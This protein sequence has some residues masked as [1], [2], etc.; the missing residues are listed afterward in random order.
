MRCQHSGCTHEATGTLWFA[1][2]EEPTFCILAI[3]ICESCTEN[4]LS[5]WQES[6]PHWGNRPCGFI[7]DLVTDKEGLI[8]DFLEGV[9]Q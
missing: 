6:N 3:P 7:P 5:F 9:E 1:Y 8:S 4:E 2:H